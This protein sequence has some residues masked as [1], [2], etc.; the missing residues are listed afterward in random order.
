[1]PK[2]SNVYRDKSS[3]KWYFVANL[4]YDETGKRI[5]Y[6]GRGYLTQR[7]AKKAYDEHMDSY[8]KTAVKLNSTMS[9]G[10]YYRTYYEPDYKSSV[11]A[12]TFENRMSAMRKHFAF[13]FGKKLKEINAPIV[14]EWQNRLA[15]D[16]SSGYVRLIFGQFQKSLD[17]AVRLGL[18]QANIARRVGN[19]KKQKNRIEFWTKEDFEKVMATFDMSDYYERF[20]FTILWLL[21]MTGARIGEL[22]ALEWS[23]VDFEDKTLTISKTMV[24]R[25]AESFYNKE[26]KTRAGSRVIALDDDTIGQLECWRAVQQKNI[27]SKYVLSY[28]GLPMSKNASGH[29]IEQHARLAD[30]HKIKTHALRHSHAAL[31]ISLGENALAIRDRLGHEDVETTLGTYGHLYPNVD[32]E[33]IGKL[34]N[35]INFSTDEK[36]RRT[37]TSNQFVK[38]KTV[39]E[40]TDKD[41]AEL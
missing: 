33:V 23:D 2:I 40:D 19:V 29:V 34:N 17:L 16:Y 27:V 24:Y 10:E 30:V 37:L 13:F 25:S 35:L 5:R 12:R 20:S 4:G 1:M 21:F 3:G 31:L 22:Q 36:S 11:S 26:P 9:Y 32:R 41:G 8:S 6:W 18:L 15:A 39:T 7:D 28:N 38:R 14:K